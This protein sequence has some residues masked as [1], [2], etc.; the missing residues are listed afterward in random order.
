MT[1]FKNEWTPETIYTITTVR[2]KDNS[3]IE[4]R[5][6]GWYRNF[7][8]ADHDVMTN[9]LDIIENGYYD[10][11]VI[12]QTPEGIYGSSFSLATWWYHI[13]SEAKGY[14]TCAKPDF[15]KNKFAWG[16]G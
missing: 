14:I 5:C 9:N 12:E 11:C 13:D 2:T 10:Y 1:T 16:I 15:A 6:V 7:F 4:R 3:V 8:E